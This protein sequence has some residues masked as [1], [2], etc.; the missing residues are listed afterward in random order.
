MRSNNLYVHVILGFGR[1]IFRL[2]LR[3][4]TDS[5][6]GVLVRSLNSVRCHVRS[7]SLY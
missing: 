7:R 2:F 4:V 6:R 3:A 5:T 1:F